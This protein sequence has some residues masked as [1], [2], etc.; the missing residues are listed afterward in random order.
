MT[1]FYRVVD[2]LVP[3]NR[4]RFRVRWWRQA[5]FPPLV[6]Y[7][8]SRASRRPST[9]AAIAETSC[10]EAYSATPFRSLFSSS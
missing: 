5:G 9:S 3:V 4:F 6:L 2:E 10:S 7:N 8:R 1:T